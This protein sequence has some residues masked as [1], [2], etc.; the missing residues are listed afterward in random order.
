[1]VSSP[2]GTT[3]S[4]TPGTS[5]VRDLRK[6]EETRRRVNTDWRRRANV[7]RDEKEDG[8]ET[9]A[10]GEEE[11]S[12]EEVEG[13]N[14]ERG[15]NRKTNSPPS[16]QRSGGSLKRKKPRVEKILETSHIPGGTWLHQIRSRLRDKFSFR[17]EGF[18]SAKEVEKPEEEHK[19]QGSGRGTP[20]QP[21]H[22]T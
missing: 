9:K 1:M 17:P 4:S 3:E 21:F 18:G 6:K 15:A 5:E 7:T 10:R 14:G 20:E 19:H 16:N 22:C 13:E 12:Q 11:E 8:R 2:G